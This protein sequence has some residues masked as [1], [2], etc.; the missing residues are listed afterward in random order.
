MYP[1]S[2]S[3]ALWLRRLSWATHSA[4]VRF[5]QYSMQANRLVQSAEAAASTLRSSAV[6]DQT[7][8]DVRG[9]LEATVRRLVPLEKAQ[10]GVL[11]GLGRTMLRAVGSIYLGREEAVATRRDSDAS[12]DEEEADEVAA[13]V[14]ENELVRETRQVLIRG[15]S[16]CWA[17]LSCLCWRKGMLTWPSTRALSAAA[18]LFENAY[19]SFLRTPERARTARQEQR[20]LRRLESTYIALERLDNPTPDVVEL[21]AQRVERA[22]WINARL[23]EIDAMGLE[24]EDEE[25]GDD[26]GEGEESE[27][28]E[29]SRRM[30]GQVRVD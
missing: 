16:E 4:D 12:L 7:R 26:E 9:V 5:V 15:E 11:L 28:E 20:L 19:A 14:P 24:S 6:S 2:P 13:E 29:L 27:E 17:M 22:L 23:V 21:R 18:G 3:P 1:F 10:G 25:E 30:E 8:H